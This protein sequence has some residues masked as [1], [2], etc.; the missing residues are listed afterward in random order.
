MK[1]VSKKN[2]CVPGFS[3]A[4]LLI[5][6]A[7]V[8]VTCAFA[9]PALLGQQSKNKVF[10]QIIR[11][12]AQ[13]VSYAYA[14]FAKTGVTPLTGTISVTNGS[15]TVTGS[16]TSFSTTFQAGD[17]IQTAS[18]A[19]RTVNATP[20]SNTS[21][22]VSSPFSA[23]ETA[24]GFSRIRPVQSTTTFSDMLVYVNSLNTDTATNPSSVP[25]GESALT[26]CGTNPCLQLQNGALLQ[27]SATNTFNGNAA[28]NYLTLAV[29]PDGAGNNAGK[30]TLL[31]YRNGRVVSGSNAYGSSGAGALSITSDPAWL[32][33]WGNG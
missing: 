6:L 32:G 12:T 4:E 2:G 30:V 3:I 13:S 22:T 31:L 1:W 21:L 27:Y 23:N 26:S 24:V 8:G 20:G 7:L 29:D 19:I 15:A 9:I 25:A 17:D 11:D 18:G 28:T 5:A 16:G 14:T 33:V 10:A